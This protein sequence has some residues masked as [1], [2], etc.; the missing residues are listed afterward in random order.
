VRAGE[1]LNYTVSVSAAGTYDIEIR[2]ASAAAGGTFHIEANGVNKTGALAVPNT[3][4]WQTWTTVRKTGVSLGAGMQVWRL[5]MDT[6]GAGGVGNFNYIRVTASAGVGGSTP[7][8]GTPTALPGTLQAENFDSG[9]EA[10][11]YHDLVPGNQGGEYRTTNVDIAVA[12]D[13]GGGYTL[14]WVGAGEWLNYSVNVGAT[15]TYALDVRVA[16]NG[17]GGTFHIEVNGV[18]KTGPLTVPSTGGWQTWA[19]IRKSNIS[20]TAGPQV[21]RI[22][23][24]SNGAS[25]AVGNFNYIRVAPQ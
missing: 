6:N 5:V 13:A 9:G 11:A 2:V 4:E 21:W 20:L 1:W 25:G 16:S 18:D 3:G 15:G 23:M 7:F 17:A 12:A 24:D 10:V 22:V 19:T 14:G 8:G